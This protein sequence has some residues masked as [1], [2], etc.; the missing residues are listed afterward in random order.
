MLSSFARFCVFY[1][2]IGGSGG[3][4]Q[5]HSWQ[6]E[7]DERFPKR[8]GRL[9]MSPAGIK[10]G[11]WTWREASTGEPTASSFLLT[12]CT[13]FLL[14]IRTLFALTAQ[15]LQRNEIKSAC[16]DTFQWIGVE[17]ILPERQTSMPGM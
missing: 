9:Q 7:L 14:H 13:F 17:F 6:G 3:K 1:F 2:F 4:H 12:L 5:E 8:A 11:A 16:A 10:L 15:L